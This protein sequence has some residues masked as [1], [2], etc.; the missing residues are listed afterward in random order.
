[1]RS[2]FIGCITLFCAAI[3]GNEIKDNFIPNLPT[4][5]KNLLTDFLLTLAQTP[6][7]YVLYGDKP[8]DIATYDLS[9]VRILAGT[10]PRTALIIKGKELWE[11]LNLSLDNK[12]YIITSFE[13]DSKCHVVCI[14]RK[15][16]VQVVNENLPLFRYVLGPTVVP[17][18]LLGELVH[19]KEQF[20]KV[21][22]ND[23]VLL[24]ILSG[25]GTHNAI[26]NSRYSQLSYLYGSDRNEEFPYISKALSKSWAFVPKKYN[27]QPSLGFR[28]VTEEENLLE[29]SLAQSTQIKSFDACPLP[30]FQCQA[31]SPETKELLSRYEDQRKKVLKA[32]GN[33][34]FLPEVLTKLFT[35]VSQTVEIPRIPQQKTLCLPNSK[36]ETIARLV[37]VIQKSI[38]SG[39]KK[40]LNAFFQGI[41]ARE[42]GQQMPLP[43]EWKRYKDVSQIQM[44]LECCKNLERANA[45]FERL[46]A[47]EDLVALVPHGI[48]YKVLKPGAEK[49]TSHFLENVSFQYSM[50]ILGDKQSKDW[51]VL[52]NES[53]SAL[54]P[55]LSL[56]LVGMMEGEERI[57][58]IHPQYA[59]GEQS[60][61]PPNSALVAQVRLLN[62]Q[63]GN[64][65]MEVF[66]PHQ[67]E[68][69]DYRDLLTRFEVLRAEE[70]FD[71]G[72]EFWDS[73][74]KSGDFI[75]FQI[76]QK[77]YNSN[78]DSV[79]FF[80][81]PNQEQQFISDLE[82]YLLLSQQR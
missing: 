78:V 34:N 24:G 48:Y 35:N 41:A 51:G 76:F 27:R 16:F 72:V 8:M 32:V 40:F 39:S 28:S 43:S 55:G 59:Y 11:D 49:P 47:R 7:G 52:K 65:E 9:S 6:C 1:M 68:K 14:N 44:D 79:S 23:P 64:R 61:F 31:D 53:V 36:E 29:K 63:E 50:Q 71:E 74:K 67:L 21:L 3:G 2:F 81:N 57:V 60:F 20:Y 26:L 45:Y 18:K 17:E 10:N 77:L 22:K 25:Q 69:R 12:E 56:A 5:Q 66:P 13:A 75:D 73:M 33:K 38:G 80:Q 54:I 82:Y 70:F 62:F 15:A 30:Q 37:G 4:N 42:K 46:A 58:Y 19:S